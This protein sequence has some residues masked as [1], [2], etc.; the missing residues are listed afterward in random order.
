M[1]SAQRA[2]NY[3]YLNWTGVHVPDLRDYSVYRKTSSGV[4]PVPINFLASSEDTVM[5]DTT[6]PAS[7]L[8]YIVTAVDVHQNQSA[9]SNEASV[10]ATTDVGNLPPVTVL[11]VQQNYPNPFAETTELQL[12]LPAKADV[13]VE[14]FDVA[15]RVVRAVAFPQR[16]AGWTR[17]R[18][19][20]RD[21]RGKNLPNGVYFY[22]VSAGAERVT[23]KLVIAR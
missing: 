19:D 9:P 12:G 14:L 2:G 13:T 22:R 20:A 16:S 6:P 10:G 5:A 8:Y 21:E 18:L 17:V 1:L 4:T 11:T 15:G 7:A 23:K 3:V